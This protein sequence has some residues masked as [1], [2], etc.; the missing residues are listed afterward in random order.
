MLA[1][2]ATF[3]AAAQET[4][5]NPPPTAAEQASADAALSTPPPS[6]PPAAE[7]ATA[8]ERDRELVE[9]HLSPFDRNVL[10]R[11]TLPLFGVP[12]AVR[13]RAMEDRAQFE[14]WDEDARAMLRGLKAT[15]PAEY[16]RLCEVYYDIKW[17]RGPSTW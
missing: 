1:L 17:R 9:K 10:N 13:A 8:A 7:P 16:R 2:A 15:N 3:P 11:W 4:P 14:Q 12:N 6:E 5:A